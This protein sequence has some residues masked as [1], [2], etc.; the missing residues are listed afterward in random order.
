[1]RQ[2][3]A[4]FILIALFVVLVGTQFQASDAEKLAAISRVVSAKVQSGLSPSVNV[5]APLEALRRQLPQR[6]DERVKSRL[7]ADK[8][9]QGIELTVVLEGNR[10]RLRGVVPDARTRK[11]AVS[12]AENTAGVEAVVDEL[13][14]PEE[15]V[16]S[17]N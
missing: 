3:V 14:V 16:A 11:V 10:I 6:L 1:V 13:A 15:R 4:F 2:F 17:K 5:T 9:L 12:L 7:T 8:R